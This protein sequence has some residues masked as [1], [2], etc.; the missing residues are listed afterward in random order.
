MSQILHKIHLYNKLFMVCL[1][2]TLIWQP[3]TLMNF[4]ECG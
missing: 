2:F 3:H 4:H 1:T